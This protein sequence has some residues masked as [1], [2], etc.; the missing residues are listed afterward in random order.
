MSMTFAASPVR[1]L[2]TLAATVVLCTPDAHAQRVGVSAGGTFGIGGGRAYHVGVTLRDAARPLG[3]PL[4]LR[5]SLDPSSATVLGA[6]ALIVFGE[7]DTALYGGLGVGYDL[8]TLRL[9][10]NVTFGVN[11]PLAPPLGAF[12]ELSW[13]AGLGSVTRFGLT[14]AF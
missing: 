3:L 13:R 10:P 4:D 8:G 9:F 12:G 5:V 11:I 1:A 14:F 7:R 6:D 2:L